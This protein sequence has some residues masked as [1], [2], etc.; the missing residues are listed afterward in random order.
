ME[1][2]RRHGVL[3]TSK[4]V[5]KK[6]GSHL[7]LFTET[8]PPWG[9]RSSKVSPRERLWLPQKI[10][11]SSKKDEGEYVLVRFVEKQTTS[12]DL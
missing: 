7:Q 12:S 4:R 1:G 3:A 8:L 9:E 6:I 2:F 10:P 11:K 5:R